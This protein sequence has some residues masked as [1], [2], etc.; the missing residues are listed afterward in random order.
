[1]KIPLLSKSQNEAQYLNDDYNSN[2]SLL[3]WWLQFYFD[4][5]STTSSNV[6]SS[7]YWLIAFNIQDFF[8]LAQYL[9]QEVRHTLHFPYI[10]EI[11]S[12][13]IQTGS[14]TFPL[15]LSVAYINIIM[16]YTSFSQPHNLDQLG[17]HFLYDIKLIRLH[18]DQWQQEDYIYK[19]AKDQTTWNM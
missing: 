4:K 15:S 13:W 16:H 14:T 5:S 6:L 2:F 9:Q 10:I 17:L 11:W 7:T 19:S 12:N 18:V 8:P 1:M 3:F